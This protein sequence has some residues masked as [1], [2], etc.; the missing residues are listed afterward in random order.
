MAKRNNSSMGK[1]A[2]KQYRGG[3]KEGRVNLKKVDGG[4]INKEGVFFSLDEKKAL[5]QAVNTAN[6]K[7]ARML[8]EEAAL[9]RRYAG[10]ESDETMGESLQKMKH[11]SDFILRP[12]SKSLH[13]FDTKE[14]YEVYMRNLR[15]VNDRNYINIRVQQYKDNFI[16]GLENMFGDDAAPL[17]ERIKEMKPKEYM[18]T[19]E[20]D[21]TL[22]FGYLYGPDDYYPK[23]NHIRNALKLPPVEW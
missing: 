20:S 10:I 19:V 4:V 7:R 5:E 16:A 14:A 22:E 3:R 2:G 12:K 18:R 6:R 21:E 11:E 23:L 1:Y 9:P 17:V 15:R 8:K 13:Q